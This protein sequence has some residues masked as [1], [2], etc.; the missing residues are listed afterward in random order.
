MAGG[1]PGS[2]KRD[3]RSLRNWEIVREEA[4]GSRGGRLV[5]R[6]I[7]RF[8]VS[9]WVLVGMGGTGGMGGKSEMLVVGG[10]GDLARDAI[11]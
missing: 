4:E 1:S 10:V 2:R 11:G 8:R 5:V 9:R 7:C 6:S 3:S